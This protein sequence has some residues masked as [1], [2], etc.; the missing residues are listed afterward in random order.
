MYILYAFYVLSRAIYI[1]MGL[2]HVTGMTEHDVVYTPLP[3]Y[4]TAGGIVGVS[5]VLLGGATC[6]IR[7][8]FSASKYWS[9]CLKYECTVIR[10][11]IKKYLKFTE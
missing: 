9:D 8:K 4:H 6:V 5:A 1:A 3:L 11:K 2:K 10:K 7:S